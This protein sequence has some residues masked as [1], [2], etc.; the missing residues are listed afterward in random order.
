M[1]LRA[2]IG[3][4]TVVCFFGG[5]ALL[6]VDGLSGG[7]SAEDGGSETSTMA[8]D[9][10]IVDLRDAQDGGLSSDAASGADADAAVADG[11]EA[12]PACVNLL[13]NSG[14]EQQVNCVPWTNYGGS[15]GDSEL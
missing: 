6:D 5:C 3:G 2:V 10:A 9:G 8:S 7:A 13:L 15:I 4:A 14:F 12:S 11:G 1:S